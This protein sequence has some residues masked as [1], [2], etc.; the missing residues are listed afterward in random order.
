MTR[1][2]AGLVIIVAMLLAGCDSGGG[3]TGAEISQAEASNATAEADIRAVLD[4]YVKAV[5]DAD[6]EGL[7]ELWAE[8]EKVSFVTPMQRLHSWDE[9]HGFW[10]GF[11]K[12]NFTKR[13]LKPDN[14][15]IRVAGEAAWVV[16]DWEFN[17]TMTDGKP[18]QSRGWE[19]Q[20]YQESERGWRIRHIH[21]SAAMTP[22]QAEGK[23]GQ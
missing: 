16:F 19:T 9:V 10:Q 15:S 21:Y 1:L 22:P 5:K 6:E 23:A 13:E 18:F 3:G 11:L 14:V 2:L 17:G 12:N 8:P 20:V 4:R 7:R